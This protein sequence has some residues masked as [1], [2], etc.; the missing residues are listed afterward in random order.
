[1]NKKTIEKV[2]ILYPLL[3]IMTVKGI[4]LEK[5]LNGLSQ[6]LIL[7]HANMLLLFQPNLTEPKHAIVTYDNHIMF[8]V[9]FSVD[10]AYCVACNVMQYC[11]TSFKVLHTS[12]TTYVTLYI[13]IMLTFYY[14]IW[15]FGLDFFVSIFENLNFK[16]FWGP[17]HWS[18]CKDHK[19]ASNSL[20]T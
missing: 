6:K 18:Y 3:P 1:M 2:W 11:I 7:F 13:R 14:H 19:T 10:L 8:E 4:L 12:T 15:N 16:S 9:S 20:S 17:A 5:K